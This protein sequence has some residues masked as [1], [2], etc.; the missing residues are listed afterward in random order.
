MRCICS[1]I[2]FVRSSSDYKLSHFICVRVYT[3]AIESVC[4]VRW[5][6]NE[7]AT[8]TTAH[9]RKI[10]LL[11]LSHHFI[12]IFFFGCCIKQFSIRNYFKLFYIY[13]TYSVFGIARMKFMYG[14]SLFTNHTVLY[15]SITNNAKQRTVPLY[16]L[17]V[18]GSF[19][20][21]ISTS[22]HSIRIYVNLFHLFLSKIVIWYGAS[23]FGSFFSILLS[24]YIFFFP[25]CF[26]PFFSA[27]W[28]FTPSLSN[29]KI[30]YNKSDTTY[31]RNP[32]MGMLLDA[33]LYHITFE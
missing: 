13:Y 29:N 5:K 19:I 33:F 20:Y 26:V 3:C 28:Q 30:M 9:Q 17:C 25:F 1:C 18:F 22:C 15:S 14:C 27:L 31:D 11:S 7:W 10:Q 24:F 4:G 23:S 8:I 16:V 6:V 12:W 32:F 2:E 21:F